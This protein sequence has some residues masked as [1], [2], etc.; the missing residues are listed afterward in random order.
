VLELLGVS[1]SGYYS[2]LKRT[3]SKQSLHKSQVKDTTMAVYLE[4]HR[5]YGAPKI[6]KILR[7]NGLIVA[8]RTVTRYMKE[9]GIRAF[10]TKPRTVTTHSVDFS[11]KLKNILDRDFTPDKP[12]AVWCTDITYIPTKKGFV[13]FVS[14]MDLFSRKII[15]WKL[16]LSLETKYVVSAIREAI[17]ITGMRPAVIHSDRGVQ[18]TSDLYRDATKN[19]TRSYSGKGDPWDN[20]CIESFHALLKRE[21]LNR[22]KIRDYEHARKLIFEYIDTFYNTQRIHSHCD[23]MAPEAYEK[24]YYHSQYD[25]S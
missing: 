3:P 6:T 24:Q 13:Y 21:C 20:A 1:S 11:E 25:I 18:Y 17:Y 19:I 8:E 14:V 9:M 15:T 5:I 23:Y 4:S 7:K 12:N 2:W 22:H 10:W 16:A